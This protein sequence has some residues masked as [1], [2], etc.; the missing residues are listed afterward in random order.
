M[1]KEELSSPLPERKKEQL[2]SSYLTFDKYQFDEPKKHIAVNVSDW[3]HLLVG[4]FIF[5]AMLSVFL[6][7]S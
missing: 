4:I 6:G 7:Q 5:V 3:K 2:I 1:V